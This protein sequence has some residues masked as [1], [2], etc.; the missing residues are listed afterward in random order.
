MEKKCRVEFQAMLGKA[1]FVDINMV[2]EILNSLAKDEYAKFAIHIFG[3]P[4]YQ[5]VC[6]EIVQLELF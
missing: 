4:T 1:N 2:T 5:F 6:Q 3:A